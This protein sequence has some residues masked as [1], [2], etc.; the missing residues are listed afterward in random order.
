MKRGKTE[1]LG[2]ILKNVLSRKSLSG[3]FQIRRFQ[4]FLETIVG[5]EKAKHIKVSGFKNKCLIV[6]VDS[7]SLVYEFEAFLREEILEKLRESGDS[8]VVKIKFEVD[9]SKS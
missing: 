5:K 7:S 1:K 2:D 6:M 9:N 8:S 4:G 3:N